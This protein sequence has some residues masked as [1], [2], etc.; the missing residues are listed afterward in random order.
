MSK[1]VVR[2]YVARFDRG[3][4]DGLRDLFHEHAQ[5]HDESRWLDLD[6]A[7]AIWEQAIDGLGVDL[8]IERIIAEGDV[9]AVLYTERGWSRSPYQGRPASGRSYELPAVDWFVIEEG[10]IA[11]LWRVRDLASQAR[12][13]GWDAPLSAPSDTVRI[14]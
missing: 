1:E 13:L 10:R 6:E 9:V 7:M 2:E 4:A 11:R 8:D 14:A 3:D 5:I 12:Q